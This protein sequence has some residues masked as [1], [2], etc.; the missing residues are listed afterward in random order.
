MMLKKHNRVVQHEIVGVQVNGDTASALVK[1]TV[2]QNGLRKNLQ[3][4]SIL[5]VVTIFIYSGQCSPF[6]PQKVPNGWPSKYL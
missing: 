1:G 5:H 4:V 6:T 3:V 2:Q